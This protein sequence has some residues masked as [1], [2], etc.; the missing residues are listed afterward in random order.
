ME[1]WSRV[2]QKLIKRKEQTPMPSH[3]K[4]STIKLSAL[5]SIS[6][7]KVNKDKKEKNFIILL[8]DCMYPIENKWTMPEIKVTIS[9][10]IKERQ[11]KEK[12]Q[13]TETV[14]HCIHGPKLNRKDS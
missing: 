12:P 6:I 13:F 4:K 8:S 11:S 2:F 7:K 10:I 3:P 14:P 5:T 9:S 1:A